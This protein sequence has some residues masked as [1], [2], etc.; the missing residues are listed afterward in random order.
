MKLPLHVSP[1]RASRYD[2][3]IV[4]R[5]GTVICIVTKVPGARE[6]AEGCV[7]RAN[8]RRWTFL[9]WLFPETEREKWLR[10]RNEWRP[11]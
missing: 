5:D 8:G 3:L 1:Q 11:Q 10:L 2:S 4:D 9:Q 6:F 7:Q